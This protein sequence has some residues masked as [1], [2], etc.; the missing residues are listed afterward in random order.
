MIGL[1]QPNHLA[2]AVRSLHSRSSLEIHKLLKDSDDFCIVYNSEEAES[3]QKVQQLLWISIFCFFLPQTT[4]FELFQINVEK[5]VEM[6]PRHLMAVA[7]SD[8]DD[9]FQQL[10]CGIRLLQTLCDLTSRHTKLEQVPSLYM[11]LRALKE[12]EFMSLWKII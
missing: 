4:D 10:L 5:M 11:C 9:K 12:F 2:A 1:L 8:K 7:M 3:P 6:L